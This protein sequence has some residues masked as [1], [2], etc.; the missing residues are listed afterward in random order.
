MKYYEYL[1]DLGD[2]YNIYTL[3]NI[4]FISVEMIMKHFDKVDSI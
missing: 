1:K 2:E 4:M 3:N